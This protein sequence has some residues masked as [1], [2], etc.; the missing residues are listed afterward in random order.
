MTDKQP[1][2]ENNVVI[3]KSLDYKVQASSAPKYKMSLLVPQSGSQSVTITPTATSETLI[4]LPAG[5]AFNLS[6]SVLYFNLTYPASGAGNFNWQPVDFC[7]A[8]NRIQL[9]T[10]GGINL[11]DITNLHK[12]LNLVQKVETKNE[13]FLNRSLINFLYPNNVLT[14]AVPAIRPV[15]NASSSKSYVEPAYAIVSVDGAGAPTANVASPAQL[16]QLNLA[17]IQNSIFSID[18]DLY[19]NEVLVLRIEWASGQSYAWYST[20]GAQPDT[21]DVAI[22]G[23][24]TISRLSLFLA[25]EQD[26][27]ITQSL[28]NKVNS[29]GLS[30]LIPYVYQFK[31]TIATSTSQNISLRFNSAHGLSLCKVYTAPY[32]AVETISTAFDHA[33]ANGAK[34]S[35]YYTMIDNSRLTEFD[36]TCTDAE[37]R[38]YMFMKDTIRGTPIEDF[39]VFRYNWL[40]IDDFCKDNQV[41]DDPNVLSGLLLTRQEVKWDLQATTANA[42]FNWYTFAVCKRMLK[43]TSNMVSIQ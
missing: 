22:V 26:E 41:S 4:E 20:N 6:D 38:D 12:Y 29:D 28:R 13:K 42:T 34:V 15:G 24:I 14:N 8:I 17:D 7:P 40:H 35:S 10:R 9:Y 36:L 3:S 18:K 43:I 11:C 19:F 31:N 25:V 23:N 39:N 1:V 16:Y 21:G 27:V 37:P 5:K 32:N 33:N 2:Q 30:V